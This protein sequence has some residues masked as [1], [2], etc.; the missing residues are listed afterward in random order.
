[1][2]D[3]FIALFFFLSICEVLSAYTDE[4][5]SCILSNTLLNYGDSVCSPLLFCRMHFIWFPHVKRK[6]KAKQNHISHML[7]FLWFPSAGSTDYALLP[8]LWGMHEHLKLI[9]CRHRALCSKKKVLCSCRWRRSNKQFTE[10]CYRVDW[11]FLT[12]F[13]SFKLWTTFYVVQSLN[14]FLRHY[15]QESTL[16]L[17]LINMIFVISYQ[18]T[19]CTK[20]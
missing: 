15:N 5:W 4:S 2:N 9:N 3:I 10:M 7:A 6:H 16:S 19:N 8:V 20:Y 18:P 12:A 11:N 1:M 13:T 17:R 14:H